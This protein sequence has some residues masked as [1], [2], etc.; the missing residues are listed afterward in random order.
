MTKIKEWIKEHKK[1]LIIGSVSTVVGAVGG[2]ALYEYSRKTLDEN[3][4]FA[5]KVYD[6][7]LPAL[8]GAIACSCTNLKEMGM[9]DATLKDCAKIVETMV[10]SDWYDPDRKITGMAVFLKDKIK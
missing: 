3:Y 8:N 1:E 2:V 7:L 9:T 6:A 4:K 5:A 10:Y